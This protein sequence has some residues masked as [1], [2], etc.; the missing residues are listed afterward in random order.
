MDFFTKQQQL[1]SQ[2]QG[3]TLKTSTIGNALDSFLK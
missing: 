2:L 1:I 3:V